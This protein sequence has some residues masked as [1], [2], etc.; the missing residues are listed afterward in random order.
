MSA[1]TCVGLGWAV[2]V[3]RQQQHE[4]E[5]QEVGQEVQLPGVTTTLDVEQVEP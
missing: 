2:R 4:H 5:Q 3:L 1:W